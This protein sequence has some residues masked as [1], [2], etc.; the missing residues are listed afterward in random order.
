MNKDIKFTISQLRQ[1]KIIYAAEACATNLI[2]ILVYIFSNTYFSGL[3]KSVIDYGVLSIGV[4]YTI[5]M[6]IGNA[7]RLSKIKKLEKELLK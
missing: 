4:G 2:C 7:L 6:G 3:F 1:D 5:F